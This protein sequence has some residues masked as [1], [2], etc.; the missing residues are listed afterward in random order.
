MNKM[1]SKHAQDI[2]TASDEDATYRFS[3]PVS[4]Q[5]AVGLFNRAKRAGLPSG[6]VIEV[7]D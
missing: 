7:R 2:R 4:A 3:R 1:L 6:S 5:R